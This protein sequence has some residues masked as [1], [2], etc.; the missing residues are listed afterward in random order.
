MD[1]SQGR[2]EGGVAPASTASS[3]AK[4]RSADGRFEAAF[5]AGP[6]EREATENGG[7]MLSVTT[8]DASFSVSWL[9]LPTATLAE[10]GPARIVQ[11][12]ED[13]RRKN[14][15]SVEKR[16]EQPLE[17]VPSRLLV[18]TSANGHIRLHSLIAVVGQRLF[19]VE[20]GSSPAT[21]SGQLEA[22]VRSF[23]PL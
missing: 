23:R 16:I 14:K 15:R 8:A 17:G 4:Y 19:Q 12:V 10:K 22:F 20:A 13:A 2:A 11:D 6:L 7:S 21:D 5:P 9:D 18:W 3:I 1:S